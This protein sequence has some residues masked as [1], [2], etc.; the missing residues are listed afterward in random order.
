M[1][2]AA[3]GFAF[4]LAACARL[5]E[6]PRPAGERRAEILKIYEEARSSPRDATRNGR[7]GMILQAYEQS[8]AAAV[9]FERARALAPGDPRWT[10]YL[11]I[12]RAS[13]QQWRE[14]AA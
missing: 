2:R 3:P 9:C 10:Y 14:A 12:A 7:L 5:P 8:G 1:R 11:G 6:L 13:L 4:L